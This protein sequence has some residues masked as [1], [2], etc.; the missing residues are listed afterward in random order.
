[1]SIS[2]TTKRRKAKAELHTVKWN[3]FRGHVGLRPLS[4]EEAKTKKPKKRGGGIRNVQNAANTK[5]CECNV[6]ALGELFKSIG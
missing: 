4:A 1:M 5:I 3:G 2:Y 6:K